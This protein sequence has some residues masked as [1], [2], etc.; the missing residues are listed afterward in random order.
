MTYTPYTQLTR[1]EQMNRCFYEV[2]SLMVASRKLQKRLYELGMDYAS[3]YCGYAT[4]NLRHC[5]LRTGGTG[6]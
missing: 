6:E 2:R 5:V 3:D 1:D 4:K